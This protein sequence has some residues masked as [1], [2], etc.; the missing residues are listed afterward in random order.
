M[1]GNRAALHNKS[2]RLLEK[3]GIICH[4]VRSA[5]PCALRWPFSSRVTFVFPVPNHPSY[6]SGVSLTHKISFRILW[7]LAPGAAH[8]SHYGFSNCSGES[9]RL[10]T[11]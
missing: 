8:R 3:E 5:T 4:E 2:Q 10:T 6:P 9:S 7:C 11:A 1:G